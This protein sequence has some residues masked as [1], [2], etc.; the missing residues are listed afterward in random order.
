M[1]IL[2]VF[3]LNIR[4]TQEGFVTKTVEKITNHIVQDIVLYTLWLHPRGSQAFNKG[5]A[6][7]LRL[8]YP[9]THYLAIES[10]AFDGLPPNTREEVIT[11]LIKEGF[12]LTGI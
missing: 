6:R 5:L 11:H 3:A 2:R 7:E 12:T 9:D 1:Y 10:D 4:T 8:T